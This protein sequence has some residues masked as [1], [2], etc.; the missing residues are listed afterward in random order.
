MKFIISLAVSC[1]AAVHCTAAPDLNESATLE[2]FLDGVITTAMEDNRVAGVVVSVATPEEI[3]ISKGYGFADVERGRPV[4]P[5]RTLFRIGS[6]SKLF[7]WL[8][9]MQLVEQGKVDLDT[10]INE[11]LVSLQIP[12]TF[13]KPVTMAHLMTHTAGFEEQV[14]GLFGRGPESLLPLA[15]ILRQELP[16]RVRPP[17]E[18]A[19]YSN[20]G[21]AVAALLIEDITGQS[22]PDYVEENILRPLGLDSISLHQPLP[23]ALQARMSNGYRFVQGRYQVQDFEFIPLT[24]AGGVSATAADITR[25][26]QMF[27]N[28]GVFHGHRILE[29]ATAKQ[30][31]T[32]LFRPA[33]G[34]N[35]TMHGFYETSS[36]GQ[37]ILGHGSDTLWFHSELIL[38]PEA[39]LVLFISTNSEGGS[40]V[41]SA[42]REGL[43]DRYFPSPLQ[44]P[45]EFPRTNPE[46]LA[47]EYGSLR[48][49]RHDL[50][51]ISR[52]FSPVSVTPAPDGGLMLAGAF[53]GEDPVYFEEISPLI[54]RKLRDESTITFEMD[55]NGLASHLYINE[56]PVMAFER[57]SGTESIAL[58][59]FILFLS[60]SVFLWILVV[61]TTQHFLR[62]TVLAP[63]L[64][65]FR[66][67]AWLLALTALVFTITLLLTINDASSIVFGLSTSVKMALMT[68]WVI[69]GLSALTLW[70]LPA[71][72]RLADIGKLAKTGY[73]TVVLTAILFSWF[74][75]QWRL[76]LWS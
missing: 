8:P 37:L 23:E 51:R 57:I 36:H 30:M 15:D 17:G 63:A 56:I 58:N 46:L 48:Y 29:E 3:L 59:F 69:V 10:D 73:L 12:A 75:I 27:L 47:G 34:F 26:G 68:A 2:A 64:S 33:P 18:Y 4:D 28:D 9:V 32:V 43:L 66:T 65:R 24:P 41:R 25:F 31:R 11:Y 52:L 74:L 39:G 50:T 60:G 61:W 44:A 71:V 19:S 5:D 7:V 54:F 72:L 55:D 62:R 42:I 53:I 13:E 21:V 45:A 35:G 49:S 6:V 1:L 70:F 76:F 16:A 14:I 40:G 22:W 67:S 38:M 20:H